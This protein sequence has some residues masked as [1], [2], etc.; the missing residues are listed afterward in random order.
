MTLARTAVVPSLSEFAE[1]PGLP[2]ATLG[3]WTQLPD[4]PQAELLALPKL[5]SWPQL[6]GLP[7]AQFPAWPQPPAFAAASGLSGVT[8]AQAQ[9][10]TAPLPAPPRQPADRSTPTGQARDSGG[11]NAPATGTVSSSWR[12]E[13]AAAGHHLATHLL[14][15]GRTV[16]YAG[17]PS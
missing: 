4:L 1:L 15:R 17:P 11:G 16:R 7:Q 6:R 14:A 8:K 5:P 9:P 3:S 2:Q 13:V 10:R 12:P